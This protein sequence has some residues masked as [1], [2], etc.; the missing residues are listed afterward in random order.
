MSGREF[1]GFDVDTVTEAVSPPP[2]DTLRTTAR[3]RRH[4][5]VAMAATALVALA[6]LAVVPLLAKPDRAAPADPPT[7]SGAQF[8]QLTLTEPGSGVDVRQDGCVVRFA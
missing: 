4:R 5:S 8:S 1:S 6:G 7:P 2:L 3:S